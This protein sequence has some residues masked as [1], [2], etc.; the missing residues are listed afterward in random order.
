VT[1]PHLARIAPFGAAGVRAGGCADCVN[2]LKGGHGPSW[3]MVVDLSGQPRGYGIYPG[4]QS[5]N[6]GSPHYAEFVAD[7]A[8]G[9]HYPLVFLSDP[10]GAGGEADH[11]LQLRGR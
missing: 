2:S 7:W 8:A 1:I 10:G 6:P 9:K 11:R 3:R 4:G 5:G